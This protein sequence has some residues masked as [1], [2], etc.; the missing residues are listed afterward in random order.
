MAQVGETEVV[1]GNVRDIV[2]RLSRD[3]TNRNPFT[4]HQQVERR[5]PPPQPQAQI[6]VAT[7]AYSSK[8]DDELSFVVGDLIE[9]ISDVEDGWSKGKLKSTGAVGMFPTNFVTLKPTPSTS[10]AAVAPAASA[11]TSAGSAARTP[12]KSIGSEVVMR[13]EPKAIDRTPSTIISDPAPV[14]KALETKF[15]STFASSAASA[16]TDAETTKTKEMARV[17]F[18]YNPQHDD[19]LALKEIDMLINITN[20]NCGDAGWFEGELH[21]K[22]GLFPDNFVELVQVPL[23]TESGARHG[24]I[25]R[26]ATLTFV[27]HKPPPVNP[28]QPAVPPKPAKISV[29][30]PPPSTI[31]PAAPSA[32][33]PAPSQLNPTS[34]SPTMPAIAPSSSALKSNFAALQEKMSRNLK[35]VAPEKV[36]SIQKPDQRDRSSTGE[37]TTGEPSIDNSATDQ[38]AELQHIT[39]NRA[40]PPKN[41]PMSMVMNRNRSSDESPNGRLSSPT[42]ISTVNPMSASMF[43]P[44]TAKEISIPSNSSATSSPFKSSSIAPP[45]SASKPALRPIPSNSLA[46]D[47]TSSTSAIRKLA[48]PDSQKSPNLPPS[49]YVS[50]AEYDALLDRF[51]ALESRVLAIEK[52]RF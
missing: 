10:A 42:S 45:S 31:A 44:A 1:A 9:L 15:S 48:S 46:D 43:V 32:P 2:N 52:I 14:L 36:A 37:S 33:A 49:D 6:Y 16:S 30:D 12:A 27:S 21:G 34:T 5:A 41:R 23:G 18:V 25:S 7:Y 8:Q 13:S 3:M 35:V 38:V 39:K 4:V 19:E 29:A 28:P 22:K 47:S 26:Q 11:S 20:K 51:R 24:S 40:R 17:K 50:R